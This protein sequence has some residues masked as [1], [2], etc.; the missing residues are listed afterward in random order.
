MFFLK[1]MCCIN[2]LAEC[3]SN[4]ICAS[5]HHCLVFAD[6]FKTMV[7]L[8]FSQQTV[9]DSGLLECGAVSLGLCPDISKECSAFVTQGNYNLE[10]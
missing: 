2:G 4:R 9:E 5:A 1:V 7:D 10:R 8:R 6:Q 3:G